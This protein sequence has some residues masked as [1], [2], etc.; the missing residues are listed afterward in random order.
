MHQ[1]CGSFHRQ[2]QEFLVPGGLPEWFPFFSSFKRLQTPHL[3]LRSLWRHPETHQPASR[4]AP[5][6]RRLK[7]SLSFPFG[8][9][10]DEGRLGPEDCGPPAGSR[11]TRPSQGCPSRGENQIPPW[12]D[13]RR[14][15]SFSRSQVT[16]QGHGFLPP[17]LVRG[18]RGASRNQEP[19]RGGRS[20]WG[21]TDRGFL[22]SNGFTWLKEIRAWPAATIW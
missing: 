9:Q 16:W 11:R 4:V 20:L 22:E 1:D 3:R 10:P 17:S 5:Q 13:G 19:S 14:P 7:N 21:Q 6:L 15:K 18:T 12:G 2:A 8:V